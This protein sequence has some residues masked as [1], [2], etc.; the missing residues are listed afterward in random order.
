[1]NKE[2][3][4][5]EFCESLQKHDNILR[6]IQETEWESDRVKRISSKVI[7]A[8]ENRKNGSMEY[9]RSLGKLEFLLKT[10]SF[11]KGPI[12]PKESAAF[13]S[14]AVSI[15]SRGICHPSILDNWNQSSPEDA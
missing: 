14:L 3:S 13:R 5:A 11:P 8:P 12:T 9:Y 15:S 7:G 10:G 6:I 2:F 1:M 4:I